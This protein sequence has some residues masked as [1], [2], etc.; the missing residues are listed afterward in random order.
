MDRKMKKV[1]LS[2]GI[3]AIVIVIGLFYFLIMKDIRG[4]Q[5][6]YKITATKAPA[7]T[8]SE[9]PVEQT[10]LPPAQKNDSLKD[11]FEQM[12]VSI[13]DQL[14]KELQKYYGATISEKSTQ[15]SIYDI[16]KS[17]VGSRP[18]GRDFFYKV[19]KRAFPELADE[20]MKT[21]DKI[22][23]YNQWLMEND[24]VL[25]Q[26]TE[27]ERL[28]ALWKKRI[29]LFGEDAKEIWT[30]EV[31]ATEARKAKMLDTLEFINTSEDTT[32]EEK[33]QLF[34]DVLQETYQGSP[35]QYF[36]DQKPI[37][38][39]IFFSVD[40]VQ[41]ELKQMSPDQRQMALNKI[42][43]EMGFT[44]EQVEAMEKVDADNNQRWDVGLKYME[45]RKKVVSEFQGQEQNE[46]LKALREKYF[47]DEAQTIQLEEEKDGFFRFER[48]RYYGRN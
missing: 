2:I 27:E 37:L 22:D 5:D 28:A 48:P 40:S 12:G 4:T 35:E 41:N 23:L 33:L 17:F 11:Q 20:I 38:A 24:A 32:I 1:W 45:E 7:T 9:T 21:L 47:Q 19:L 13:E 10:S 36:L 15:A 44:Q 25:S 30:D 42:R 3:A 34:Q 6:Q 14:V 8:A 26:M 16:R 39:K 18:D 43:R 29:E 46:K 31:M